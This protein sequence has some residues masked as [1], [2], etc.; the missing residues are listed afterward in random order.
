[1]HVFQQSYLFA[2]SFFQRLCDKQFV[3]QFKMLLN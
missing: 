1:M 2:I 3:Q